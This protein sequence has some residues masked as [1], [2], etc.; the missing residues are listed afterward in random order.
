MQSNASPCA[1]ACWPPQAH[2]KKTRGHQLAV[3]CGWHSP[4]PPQ[5]YHSH[6][7][8]SANMDPRY[9]TVSPFCRPLR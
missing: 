2:L 5:L 3:I 6:S 1:L 4:V 9:V 8:L 7:A